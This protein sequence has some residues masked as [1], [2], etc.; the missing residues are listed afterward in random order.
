MSLDAGSS[1]TDGVLRQVLA[2]TDGGSNRARMLAAL[3][4]R[5]RNA[6]QLDLDR[7]EPVLTVCLH[8]GNRTGRPRR[9]VERL[10][11]RLG[12]RSGI[13]L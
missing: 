2:G 7:T 9:L 13:G 5:P 3:A 1:L 4:D 8:D 10:S 11:F 6:S 12:T